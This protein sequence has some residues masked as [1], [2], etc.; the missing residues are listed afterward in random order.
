MQGIIYKGL[1]F[2]AT[3][4]ENAAIVVMNSSFEIETIY[5]P[6]YSAG[7]TTSSSF[8]S[9]HIMQSTFFIINVYASGDY[10]GKGGDISMILKFATDLASLQTYVDDPLY[11]FYTEN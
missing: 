8:L 5:I 9:I 2:I 7:G 3:E 11:T 10:W 6:E 1:L 4:I